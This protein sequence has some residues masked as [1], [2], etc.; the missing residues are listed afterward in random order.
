MDSNI[1]K[2]IHSDSLL[3][4]FESCVKNYKDNVFIHHKVPGPTSLEFKALTYGQV[5]S[6]ATNLANLWEPIIPKDASCIAV[7]NDDPIQAALSFFASLKLGLIICPLIPFHPEGALRCVDAIRYESQQNAATTSEIVMDIKVWDGL[8]D[9][10]QQLYEIALAESHDNGKPVVMARKIVTN[11][12]ETI[13]YSNTS[14][15][16]SVNPKLIRWTTRSIVFTPE[17]MLKPI[18]RNDPDMVMRSSDVMVMAF[19]AF[20]SGASLAQ[21]ILI[22]VAGASVI[23]HLTSPT[24]RILKD[25]E[26]AAG[27]DSHRQTS[28]RIK[29]CIYGGAPL[30]DSLGRYLRSKGLNIRTYYG[31]T[32]ET[33]GTSQANMAKGNEHWDKINMSPEMMRYATFE[34]YNKKNNIYN[35]VVHRT[36]PSL[37]DGVANRPSGDYATRDLFIEDPPSYWRYIGRM[38]DILNLK[39]GAL[40]N[41]IPMEMEIYNS[42]EI[43]SK[44]IIIGENRERTAV[45]VELDQDKSQKYSHR[46]ITS[47]GIR[48]Y[49]RVS[50]VISVPEMVYIL[51]PNR[52]LPI[53]LKGIVARKKVP[54]VFKQE[55]EGLYAESF[56]NF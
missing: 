32:V 55:I 6:M 19:T 28:E 56:I 44:C 53:N 46:E 37:A 33:F 12:K 2:Y 25:Q 29:Y 23:S 36:Y 16:T 50:G 27:S 3:Q 11:P 35:L 40:V 9:I 1:T 30:Q 18:Q 51:P 39:M 13:V 45:L 43:I 52:R 24:R 14:G 41:P 26:A 47:K 48:V 42:E 54:D 10:M 31:S 22:I 20:L 5:D 49:S 15:S 7:F 38:D 34:P 17:I 21:L 4:V 8:S